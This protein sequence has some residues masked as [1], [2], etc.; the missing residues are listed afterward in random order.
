MKSLSF[1]ALCVVITTVSGTKAPQAPQLPQRQWTLTPSEKEVGFFP[2]AAAL[3]FQL[4]TDIANYQKAEALL[5]K[6]ADITSPASKKGRLQLC[7]ACYCKA[8]YC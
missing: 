1:L 4:D 3:T 6:D 8:N 2:T 7:I 5:K